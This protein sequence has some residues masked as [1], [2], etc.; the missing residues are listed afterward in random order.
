MT[1]PSTAFGG[2]ETAAQLTDAQIEDKA[3]ELLSQLSLDE[4]LGL[5]D[6]DTR[7]WAGQIEMMQPGGYSSRPWVA[8]AVE[9]L[10]I[11]GIRFVDG[12]RGIIMKGATTFP[13]SMA[14]GA[15]WDIGLEE[16][17]GDA[18]GRELRALGGNFFGGVCINLLRHPAWGRAQEVYGEDSYHLGEFGAALTRGVQKHVMAC[19]KHY[20]LNSM[21]NARFVVDVTADDRA[22][23]EVYLPHFKRVI[24]E[25]VASVM[26]AYNRVNG[27]WCG[28]N[29][30][31][32]NDILKEMWGFEG[33]VIT[34]FI[35]GMRDS[36]EAV[37]AG[38]DIE[39]PFAMHHAQY[40]KEL[41]ENGE[42]PESRIND[43]ALRSLRQQIRFAQRRDANYYTSDA[44]G[45][46]E[47]R[48]LA[49]EAAEKSVVLLKNEGDILPLKQV[50]K[51][52]II[53]HLADTVNT[54][55]GGSSNT[56]PDYVITPLEGIQNILG[57]TIE[58]VYHDGKDSAEAGA[59]AKQADVALLVVGYTHHDEGEFIDAATFDTLRQLYP[60]PN[61]DEKALA[62]SLE[63][64]TA[65]TQGFSPGGDRTQLT[66]KA[67][68][69]ALIQAVAAA[70][71]RT[72]VAVMAGSAVIMENWREQVGTIL[73]LWYPGMEGGHA[74]A[75]ILIGKVN[76]SG[77][78]PCTFPASDTH[79]PYFDKDAT[80]IT[81]DLW[82]GYRKL[83]HDG[84]SAAFPFG[85]GLSYTSFD[86]K[87]LHLSQTELSASDTLEITCAVTNLGE[88]AGDEVVQLY[89]APQGSKIER[90]PKELKAFTRIS[91]SPNETKTVQLTVPV[92]NLAYYDTDNG[93]TVE[94]IDYEVI[95]ARHADD[96][97]ALKTK[98]MVV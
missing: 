34:D 97:D 98:F 67:E 94:E 50:K 91:L 72:I 8:G 65:E 62:E 71:T 14:R 11:P 20:A 29:K 22:L 15:S 86:Y 75:N 3:K 77:K 31:L 95:V 52:A 46:E 13:V 70:N 17:I 83:D 7:F 36:K 80:E 25:G 4:K 30:T 40:L 23:H 5:M 88:V 1:H 21:E 45:S 89:I 61:E 60:S 58:I 9:R 33:F 47:H 42:V 68:D 6:G 81:Y 82:H 79:L 53:G 69:E 41:V 27:E 63:G 87:N 93:W 78:L 24:D 66:L 90:A 73:M 18:I 19:V 54:G 64:R 96:P 76:P 55:D 26:S 49:R 44:I 39:M 12:P 28:E 57:D 74:L 51:L 2:L 32:L 35:F 16:S 85:F 37:L 38:L 84:N 56:H 10:G 92:E 48:N 59:I 43:A